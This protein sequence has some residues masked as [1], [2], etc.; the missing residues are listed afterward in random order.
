MFNSNGYTM[1]QLSTYISQEK[2]KNKKSAAC[3]D[4]YSKLKAS[5]DLRSCQEL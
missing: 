1:G 5:N 4:K 3:S 2:N